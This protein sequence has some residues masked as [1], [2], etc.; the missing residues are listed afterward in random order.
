[1]ID[2]GKHSQFK[3][4][5]SLQSVSSHDIHTFQ[6]SDCDLNPERQISNR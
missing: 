1:M 4:L 6:V 3:R 5:P 2:E